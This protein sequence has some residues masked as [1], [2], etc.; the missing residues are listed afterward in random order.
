VARETALGTWPDDPY[1]RDEAVDVRT[2]LKAMTIWTARQ[3]FLE[4][5]IGSIEVGKYAD[6]A[7]WDRDLYGVPT[8]QLKDMTCLLTVFDGKIVYQGAEGGK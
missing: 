8:A 2:A 4:S 5:K 1:G 6:L 7:V 3:M